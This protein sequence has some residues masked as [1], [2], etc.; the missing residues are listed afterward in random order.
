MRRISELLV[1]PA[2]IPAR[3]LGCP[4]EPPAGGDHDA[5]LYGWWCS[6]VDVQD[7]G[8]YAESKSDCAD[9][10]AGLCVIVRRGRKKGDATAEGGDVSRY[11]A[12]P[13]GK[14]S[15]ETKATT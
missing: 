4:R 6:A 15:S 1:S 7:S 9:R 2:A 8:R 11:V 10:F 13:P 3:W 5:C 12:R 14:P